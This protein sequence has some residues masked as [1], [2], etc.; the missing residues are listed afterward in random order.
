MCRWFNAHDWKF[1]WRGPGFIDF[2]KERT[3][4]LMD[5]VNDTA[6]ECRKCGLVQEMNQVKMSMGDIASMIT[7]FA[8]WKE[9]NR[10][11]VSST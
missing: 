11:D 10:Y 2:H 7:L 1:L 3:V 5:V 9:E 8:E 4:S 6:R